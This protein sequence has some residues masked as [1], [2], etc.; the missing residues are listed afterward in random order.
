MRKVVCVFL[1]SCGARGPSV[2]SAT[3]DLEEAPSLNAEAVAGVS[4]PALRLLLHDHWEATMARN[5]TWAT[6][7][8]DHRFDERLSDRSD[9]AHRADGERRRAWLARVQEIAEGDLSHA[10]RLTASLFATEL[11]QRI[12]AEV[13]AFHLWSLSPRYHVVADLQYLPELHAGGTPLDHHRIRSRMAALPDV[14]SDE[15]ANLRLG[16]ERKLVANAESTRRVIEILQAQIDSPTDDWPG[17]KDFD[18]PEH[19]RVTRDL[20]D[21][22]LRPKLAT[23]AQALET[24]ILPVARPPEDAGMLGLPQGEA[25]YAALVNS[26][27]TLEVTADDRHAI[28]LLALSGIHQEMAPILADHYGTTELRAGFDRIRA[29][30][31]QHFATAAEIEQTAKASLARA[32]AAMG[33]SFGRLPQAP[34]EVRPIPSYEAPYTTIAYYRPPHTDG[35]KPGEYFVNTHAPETRPR[36]EAEVLAFHEAIPGHHL[37]IAISQELSDIPAFRKHMGMTAFVEGWALYTERLA[38][39]MGLYTGEL[40]RFGMLSFDS[41]RA[42]RLVVDTGLHAEGW[43]RQQAVDFMLDNTPLAKNNIE[44]EVDRYL[45]WPGQALAY[46]SGQIEILD[47]R[48][49]AEEALGEGF[50]L[51]DFHDVVLGAGAVTMPVLRARVDAWVVSERGEPGAAPP[52]PV[53]R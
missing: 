37:Q 53:S 29:D 22:S 40:D 7:L 8:G 39:E 23:F 30:P 33:D 2:G 9:A 27:T 24:E 21:T 31:E 32:E 46:K 14:L 6:Q 5:P 44:N 19:L 52:S 43:T 35:T 1:L 20:V 34:C 26:Y 42:A 38:D 13:C 48:A 45:T 10:D 17:V 18:D 16:K 4:D 28:G 11:Q 36:F 47:M 49:A 41:W 15:L 50:V 25:C 51:A 12:D 3:V